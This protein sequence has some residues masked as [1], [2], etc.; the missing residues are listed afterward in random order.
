MYL[1]HVLAICIYVLRPKT[2]STINAFEVGFPVVLLA[3][4][5]I[6][7]GR[8]TSTL[9]A[10]EEEPAIAKLVSPTKASGSSNACPPHRAT[11]V[12]SL[13]TLSSASSG[14]GSDL[15]ESENSD[16][17]DSEE[18]SGNSSSSDDEAP[19]TANMFAPS[20]APSPAPSPLGVRP[21]T[22]VLLL[23]ACD[24]TAS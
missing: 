10:G 8:V 3:L 11:S 17:T 2:M 21:P 14:I 7:Y 9:Q 20:A 19:P 24:S 22:A 18:D 13:S 15:A 4:V 6:G 5:A 1:L 12:P 16:S 23:S